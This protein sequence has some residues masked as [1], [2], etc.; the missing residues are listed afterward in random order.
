M[1]YRSHHRRRANARI[2]GQAALTLS[3]SAIFCGLP[4]FAQAAPPQSPIY[5]RRDVPVEKRIQDLI[6]RMTVEEK[7]RQLDLYSGIDAVDKHADNT[8]FGAGAKFLP[9]N[10]AKTWGNL[11]AGGIHDIYTTPEIYNTMQR[12]VIEHNRLGIPAIFI[13]EGL[14]GFSNS[15]RSGTVYPQSINLATTWNTDLARQ[16]GAGIAAEARPSG[17]NMLLGPVLDVAREPRWGR[18]EEDFGE[19]PYL[20]G[21]LGLSYVLGM[22]GSSLD[23]DHTVIAEPKHFAGHGSPEG[24][25]N[26]S[27]VH[28]GEREVRTIMLRSFEPAFRNGKAMGVMAAYHEIDGIPCTSNYWLMTTVLR[29]EWGFQGFVLSDLG[30]IKKLYDSHHVAATPGDAVRMALAAGVDMQ[31]Y[32]FDHETYQNA[33]IS[34]IRSGKLSPAALDLAVSRV[35]RAKFMLGLFDHPYV[36]PALAERRMRSPGN[37]ALSLRSSRESMCLLKNDKNLLPLSKDIGKIAVIGPNAASIQLGD[38]AQTGPNPTLV[39]LL[40]GIKSIVSK[41]TEVLSSDGKDIDAAVAQAKQADVIV[42]GLGERQGISGESYDRST[43]DLPDNQQQ[44]LEAVVATGVP[45]VLVL[46]NGRPLAIPWAAEHVPAILEAWYPGE[47]GGQAMAETLFGDNNPAG[48]LPVSFPRSVGTLPDFYN[49]DPSKG[50]GYIDNNAAPLFPFGHGLSY[51]TFRYDGLTAVPSGPGKPV[52]VAVTVNVTNTGK[53][54]GDEVAQLYLHHNTSS[55]ETPDR[56]LAGFRRIS[57][58]P[59]ETRAVT[60]HLT[61]YE[62]EIWNREGK[63]A[64]ENGDYTVSIGGSSAAGQSTQFSFRPPVAAAADSSIS[65]MPEDAVLKGSQIRVTEEMGHSLIGYWDYATE[66]PSWAVRVPAAGKYGVQVEYSTGHGPTAFDVKAA[67]Q[68][69]TS[70]TVVTKGWMDYKIANLGGI[71]FAKAG[72]Y[73]VTVQPHDSNKWGAI[74]VRS[75]RLTPSKK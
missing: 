51:T 11:G 4:S 53:R 16:T 14:H 30:A 7:A 48:R 41:K 17:V 2:A 10:A 13:E 27:P 1:I 43:L 73:T 19:D 69:V 39:T 24:G 38:Y 31:F 56:A 45:V 66:H 67:G 65:L 68:A 21:Q 63:W 29:K 46:Q 54:A 59:G 32:D 33:I 42:L 35:L 40:D 49:H 57:L 50:Q 15:L 58:R 5:R 3:F 26:M 36:D 20:T 28:A 23:T 25:T 22:Q 52:D 75:V 9:E 6:R 70:G 8:H 64:V 55:V 37:L 47:R 60:F 44:L 62:V 71:N 72:L 61:P 34:G 74:N 12:W 18:V